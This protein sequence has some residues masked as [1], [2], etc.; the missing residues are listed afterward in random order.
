MYLWRIL[1][2]AAQQQFLS[3]LVRYSYHDEKLL[4]GTELDKNIYYSAKSGGMFLHTL[5]IC[6]AALQYYCQGYLLA[7]ASLGDLEPGIYAVLSF[8]GLWWWIHRV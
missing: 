2:V 1:T 8:S 4:F 6:Q 7:K 3:P 5:E